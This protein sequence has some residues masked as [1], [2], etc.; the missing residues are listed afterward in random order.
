MTFILLVVSAKYWRERWVEVV[1]SDDGRPRR[2][3]FR[4]DPVFFGWSG[5]RTRALYNELRS[6]VLQH[7]ATASG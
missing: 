7:D 5:K 4:R 3:Y 1:Y 2:A 6:R